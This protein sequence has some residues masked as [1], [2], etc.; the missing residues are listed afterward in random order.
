M[1][2]INYACIKLEEEA[3]RSVKKITILS[4]EYMLEINSP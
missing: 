3:A 4:T 2:A 1:K